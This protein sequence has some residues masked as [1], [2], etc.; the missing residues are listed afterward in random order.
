MRDYCDGNRGRY[1][2]MDYGKRLVL[3]DGMRYEG[4]DGTYNVTPTDIDGCIQLDR[5]N[6]IIFIELKY[7]GHIP[8]GQRSAL[9]AICNA[10]ERGGTHSII[11]QAEHK[12]QCSDIHQPIIAGEAIVVQIYHK[13]KWIPIK[14]KRRLGEMIESYIRYTRMI[15][16]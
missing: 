14:S 11:F 6:C 12:T 8:N 3:F 2:Y 5:E 10:I 13:G 15:E 1:Q 16:E 9:E 7:A 4:R